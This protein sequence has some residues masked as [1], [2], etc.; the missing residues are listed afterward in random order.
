M[1]TEELK[2]EAIKK[3]YGEYWDYFKTRHNEN[4]W[5]FFSISE[6]YTHA[7]FREIPMDYHPSDRFLFR[8]E[9]LSGIEDNNGWI[10]IKEDGSNL[11]KEHFQVLAI[12]NINPNKPFTLWYFPESDTFENDMGYFKFA[13]ISHYKIIDFILP[14]Y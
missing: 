13:E 6:F 9:S 3:A 4:G 2:F 12:A 5:C 11:P 10:R 8:P 7:I 1:T 14:I